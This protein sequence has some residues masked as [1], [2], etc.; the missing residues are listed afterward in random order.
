MTVFEVIQKITGVKE[1][2]NLLYAF[3]VKAGSPEK[4]A[5]ALSRE[6]SEKELRIIKSAAQSGNYPLSFDGMQ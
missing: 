5:E 2:S 1:F 4:L 3:A 6:L